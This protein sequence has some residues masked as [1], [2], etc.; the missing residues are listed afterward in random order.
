[1][2]IILKKM[3]L[4]CMVLST[5]FVFEIC[6]AETLR[7][8]IEKWPSGLDFVNGL[9]LE[10][11]VIGNQ[12]YD[13]LLKKLPS[14]EIIPELAESWD[15][16][17]G[18]K[19]IRFKLKKGIYFSDGVKLNT[20]HIRFIFNKYN[21]LKLKKSKD[22]IQAI[23]RFEKINELE[24]IIRL[25]HE[26]SKFLDRL[27]DPENIVARSTKGMPCAIG[28]GAYYISNVQEK[29]GVIILSRNQYSNIPTDFSTIIFTT[30]KT[31]DADISFVKPNSDSKLIAQNYFD[32][33][34]HYLGIFS[35]HPDYKDLNK[36]LYLISFLTEDVL[37]SSEEVHKYKIGG[38]IPYGQF[39]H[40]QDALLP[41]G[42]SQ[43][44]HF[45]S[46]IE[47]VY[48]ADFH[49]KIATAYCDNLKKNGLICNL[50]KITAD[51][52]LKKTEKGE[53]QVYFMRQKSTGFSSEDI[54]SFFTTDSIFNFSF[55][56]DSKNPLAKKLNK[57]F[58][59]IIKIPFTDQEL[60]KK[61]YIQMDETIIANGLAKPFRYGGEKSVWHTKKIILP[62]I[63]TNGPFGMMLNEVKLARENEK[64]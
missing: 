25:E 31:S 17:E 50:Q 32:T 5:I 30:K 39:G 15:Y 45:S 13:T 23:A 36:R 33:E 53:L 10:S 24:F 26:D 11:I 16:E 57:L 14:G 61:Y 46:P 59:S 63:G 48:Y 20:E 8:N 29:E 19:A 64:R 21:K 12:V 28:T 6:N 3:L 44:I 42:K 1:M 41:I 22:T 55:Y 52:Y 40:S 49:Q 47:V 38:I 2:N 54:L 4:T 56:H 35:D 51:E 7:I 18:H 62:R 27:T 60:L 9:T 43:K 34:V 58:L 37:K